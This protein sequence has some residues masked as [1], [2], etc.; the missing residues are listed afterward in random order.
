MTYTCENI[1][2][3]VLTSRAVSGIIALAFARCRA[4]SE[5]DRISDK[6]VEEKQ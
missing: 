4:G 1:F 5:T 2:F 3:E 6:C